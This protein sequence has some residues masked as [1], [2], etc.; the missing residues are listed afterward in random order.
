M[1]Y[2]YGS[3]DFPFSHKVLVFWPTFRCPSPRSLIVCT[4]IPSPYNDIMMI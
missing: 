4:D 2:Q 3:E 1:Q